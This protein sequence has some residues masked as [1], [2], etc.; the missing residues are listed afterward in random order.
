MTAVGNTYP[1]IEGAAGIADGDG[2]G[3]V[4]EPRPPAAIVDGDC[5]PS[6]QISIEKCL[7]GAPSRAT[8]KRNAFVRGNAPCAPLG[9]DIMI[10]AHSIVDV[11][12]MV[13]AQGG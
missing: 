8:I 4:L 5:S 11:A 2:I 3:G 10:V 1:Q 9:G 7:T 12:I 13:H 6:H